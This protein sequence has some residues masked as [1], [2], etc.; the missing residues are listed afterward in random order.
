[1]NGFPALEMLVVSLLV[2]GCLL[3]LARGAWRAVR[4]LSKPAP[5]GGCGG[6]NACGRNDRNRSR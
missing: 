1:M 6:C 2:G 4:E 5:A 3:W